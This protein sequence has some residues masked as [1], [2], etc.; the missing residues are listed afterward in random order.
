MENDFKNGF[1]MKLAFHRHQFQ[2]IWPR[3][4]RDMVVFVLPRAA[5][6]AKIG[7]N[8]RVVTRKPY[9]RLRSY[10]KFQ[11]FQLK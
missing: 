11:L 4:Y 7:K 10:L 5:I 9:V 8:G 3:G 6:L 2:H 1:V